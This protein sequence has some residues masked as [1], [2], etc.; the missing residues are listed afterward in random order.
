MRLR[1]LKNDQ[2]VTE[3]KSIKK[4]S[5]KNTSISVIQLFQHYNF[6][7]NNLVGPAAF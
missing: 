3:E 7:F 2:K 1:E 5:E 4:K 6:R